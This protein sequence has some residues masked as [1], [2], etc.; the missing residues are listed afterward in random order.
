ML[1]DQINRYVAMH[2]AL[3]YKYRV[4]NY[5][6]QSFAHFAEAEGD[7]HVRSK[8]V[9]KWAGLAPSVLQKRNRLLTVRRFAIAVHA[10]DC[11]HEVP[12]SDV[13]GHQTAKRKIRHL[14]S[15]EDIKSLLN[16]ASRLK[17]EGSI[18]PKTYSTLF[19]LLATTGL[20]SCEAIALNIEDITQ[21]GLL[22]KSTKFRKDRL[23]P[24]HHSAYEAL[25][26]YLLCRRPF[27][28]IT[29]PFFVSNNGARLSYSTINDIFLQLTRSIGLRGLP[30]EAGPCMH[31]LRHTFAV[32]SLEQCSGSR[33][34]ISRHM[35]AL[36]TYLGHAH[37]SDTYW[38]LQATPLLFSQIAMDQETYHGGKDHV[39]SC[40][41]S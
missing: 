35:T 18:R 29:S 27:N 2:R 24:L 23:V 19:A 33:A 16:A 6:L 13:F 41:I 40:P 11:R 5:L 4:Q 14:F 32:R 17:P 26:R 28:D 12:P 15:S 7:T 37:L 25:Q 38:Y 21:D 9:I 3:G 10:E 36:S 34:E 8:T 22:V 31:D 39:T 1:R 20:R 30:G